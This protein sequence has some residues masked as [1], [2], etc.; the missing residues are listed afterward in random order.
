MICHEF[1]CRL[2]SFALLQQEQANSDRGHTVTGDIAW[3]VRCS[4]LVY[5]EVL[6][7]YSKVPLRRWTR[8]PWASIMVSSS[9]T[10]S[11]ITTPHG[12]S[13]TAT[14]CKLWAASVMAQWFHHGLSLSPPG[15]ASV[16]AHAS[17]SHSSI[18]PSIHPW[19]TP[20]LSSSG[21]QGFVLRLLFVHLWSLSFFLVC[22]GSQRSSGACGFS[23]C[24]RF[25]W[26]LL[27]LCFR[28]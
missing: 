25:A 26:C 17:C 27:A 1:F 7:I 20:T 21:L 5:S 3:N 24:M 19:S 23:F 9:E 16:A 8:L 11:E 18:H 22:F 10:S 14:F 2:L 12:S 15:E 4:E 28:F 6:F 13:C